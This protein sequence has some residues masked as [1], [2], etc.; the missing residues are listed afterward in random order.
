MTQ[1]PANQGFKNMIQITNQNSYTLK[2]ID[3]KHF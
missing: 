3:N 2:C 1:I